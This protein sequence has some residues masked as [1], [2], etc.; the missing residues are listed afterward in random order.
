[1]GGQ[2]EAKWKVNKRFNGINSR[3]MGQ[4]EV[5]RRQWEINEG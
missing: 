1:M 2:L 3:V 4:S 5:M